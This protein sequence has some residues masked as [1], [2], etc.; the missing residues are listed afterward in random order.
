MWGAILDYYHYTGDPSY[1]DV[2]I[3]ALLA[4]A[5][6]GPNSDFMPPIHQF[7]E[8]NDDLGFWGFAVMSAAERNF[9][10]PDDTLPSWLRPQPDEVASISPLKSA[11][12][13]LSM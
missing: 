3:Q 9:P 13:R 4:P 11:G 10:Q 7:E 12:R 6:R 8:G 5:N 2:F 1:N